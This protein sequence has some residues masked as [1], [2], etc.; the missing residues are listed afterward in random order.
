MTT[1]QQISDWYQQGVEEGHRYMVVVCD[2]FYHE[3]YPVFCR[4]AEKAQA[5]SDNPGSMQRVMERYD[6]HGDKESQLNERRAWCPL[7]D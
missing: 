5:T 1:R 6:L 3:D 2:T 4:S 7:N